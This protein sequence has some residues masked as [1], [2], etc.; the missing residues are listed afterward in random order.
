MVTAIFAVFLRVNGIIWPRARE[1]VAAERVAHLGALG[2]NLDR[3]HLVL[4]HLCERAY[5][6][7][8]HTTWRKFKV[9]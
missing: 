2:E 8:K 3:G 7:K 6:T 4:G 5:D 9:T 1:Q